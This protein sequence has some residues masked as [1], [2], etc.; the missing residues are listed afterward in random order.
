[1]QLRLDKNNCIKK[2]K[3]NLLLFLYFLPNL[4]DLKIHNLTFYGYSYANKQVQQYFSF[5][6]ISSKPTSLTS[7]EIKTIIVNAGCIDYRNL[8]PATGVD[9]DGSRYYTITG[10]FCES[11][12]SNWISWCCAKN[13]TVETGGLP[14]N[15]I[16]YKDAIYSLE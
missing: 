6:L 7:D 13:D 11:T 9:M 3:S 2:K 16:S 5:S 4:I 1:M 14:F 12:S 8:I 15:L 10:V